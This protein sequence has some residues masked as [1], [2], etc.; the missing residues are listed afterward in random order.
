MLE[1]VP[2]VGDSFIL[3]ILPLRQERYLDNSGGR[4][5][6]VFQFFLQVLLHYM[7]FKPEIFT[8]YLLFLYGTFK[9]QLNYV[10]HEAATRV[11]KF[12]PSFIENSNQ[13]RSLNPLWKKTLGC[14][15]L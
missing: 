11:K 4:S 6:S 3:L 13:C 1:I 14:E 9:R 8:S 12:D 15:A 7:S 10:I 5:F 2:K